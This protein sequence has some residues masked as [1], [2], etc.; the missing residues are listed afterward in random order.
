VSLLSRIRNRSGYEDGDASLKTAALALPRGPA[1]RGDHR[2]RLLPLLPV[3]RHVHQLGW[4]F[5]RYDQRS[6]QVRRSEHWPSSALP[7]PA[8]HEFTHSPGPCEMGGN[9]PRGVEH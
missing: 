5:P 2:D 1:P 7:G 9:A 3:Y 8:C 4:T 6:P